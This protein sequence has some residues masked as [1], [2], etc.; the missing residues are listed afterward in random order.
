M[1]QEKIVPITRKTGEVNGLFGRT[2]N[3]IVQVGGAGVTLIAIPLAIFL[4][5]TIIETHN[6]AILNQ[7]RMEMYIRSHGVTKSEFKELQREHRADRGETLQR[8]AKQGDLIRD[9][10]IRGHGS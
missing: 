9:H 6:I 2:C 1:N 3:R 10:Q 7:Q 5:S 8:L 4:G